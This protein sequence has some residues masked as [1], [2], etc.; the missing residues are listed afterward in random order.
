MSFVEK[1]LGPNEHLLG[2]AAVHWIYG[3]KGL[4]W[5][6]VP[7]MLVSVLEDMT[8]AYLGVDYGGGWYDLIDIVGNVLFWIGVALGSTMCL[9]YFVLMVSTELGLTDKRIILKK[10]LLFVDVKEIDLDEFKAADVDHGILGRFLNYGYIKLDSRF[11]SDATLPAIG[12]PYR[13]LKALNEMRERMG[14]DADIRDMTGDGAKKAKDDRKY[15]LQ[16]ER[17]RGFEERSA[18][19][20]LEDVGQELHDN[21]Q[22]VSAQAER[23][24]RKE[25]QSETVKAKPDA[26][27]A[28]NEGDGPTVFEKD[29]LKDELQEELVHDF[30]ESKG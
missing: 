19:E 18:S 27:A 5:L 29:P 9:F 3:V 25:R 16:D 26:T 17:Y 23:A 14:N 1:T 7:L 8:I 13:F 15:S 6:F 20:S 24:V 30:E 22:Q 10:G 21:V 12:A 2:L 4:L 11:I 28:N